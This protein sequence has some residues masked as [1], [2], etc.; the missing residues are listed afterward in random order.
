MFEH[1]KYHF[2]ATWLFSPSPGHEGQ[3]GG[4]TSSLLHSWKGLFFALLPWARGKRATCLMLCHRQVRVHQGHKNP[5]RT[6]GSTTDTG[7]LQTHSGPPGTS[8]STRDTGFQQG[9]RDP[10]E[11]GRFTGD[12]KIKQGHLHASEIPSCEGH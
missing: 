5:P 3:G 4:G 6:L 9:Q 8:G 2:W 1:Y 11:T 12:T 7:V 10:P